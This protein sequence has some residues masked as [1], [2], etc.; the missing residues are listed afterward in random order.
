MT[1]RLAELIHRVPGLD[2]EAAQAARQRHD[3]LAKPPGSLGRLEELGAWLAGV[4]GVCPPPVPGSPWAVLAAGDHAVADRGVTAWPQSVTAAMVETICSHRASVS[5][6]A[7]A[8]GA[9]VAVVDAGVATDVGKHPRLWRRRVRRGADDIAAAPAMARAEATRAIVAGAEI[10]DA[11]ADAG[12]DM[13]VTGDMGVANTTASTCLIAAAT[14][15]PVDG[16]VGP[17]AG[18]GH[19]TAERKQQAVATA[20]ARHRNDEQ[21]R[22]DPLGVLAGLGGLEHA[23][24]VGVMLA[25]AGR[26]LPV[27]LDGLASDAAALSATALCPAVGG[28]LLAGHRSDEPAAGPA[29]EYL[30]LAAVVELGLSLGEGSGGLLAVTTVTAAAAVLARTADI[31]EVAASTRG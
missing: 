9:E 3:R 30:G 16:L 6:I 22:G 19:E 1:Q 13:V 15:T 10:T 11:L 27:V 5:A 18:G 14:G 7:D 21:G 31:D 8:V 26:R 12:A 28:F 17:G 24:L 23:A 25:A 20:L 4:A 2:H 29:L